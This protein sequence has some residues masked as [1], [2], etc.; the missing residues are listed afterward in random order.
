MLRV[1][2]SWRE[3]LIREAS[4]GQRHTQLPNFEASAREDRQKE[5]NK[6][7][8]YLNDWFWPFLPVNEGL[9]GAESDFRFV[10]ESGRSEC[11]CWDR[12][13]RLLMA[14]AV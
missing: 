7:R 8:N 4:L 12:A 13:L 11:T 10:L 6:Y 9:N 5:I 2:T 1:C 14:E 3:W